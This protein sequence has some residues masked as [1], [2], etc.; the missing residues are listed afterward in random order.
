MESNGVVDDTARMPQ[1]SRFVSLASAL[2]LA[3]VTVAGCGGT[4]G[5]GGD[6]GAAD[7]ATGVLADA[8]AFCVGETNRLRATVGKAAVVQS[9]TLEDYADAGAMYDF[10]RQPHDHFRDAGGVAFAENECPHWDLSFGNG[11]LHDLVGA[12]IQAFWSEGPGGGHY[13]NMTG[14]YGSLGCGFYTEGTEYTII[15]DYR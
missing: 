8:H 1:L 14:N 3:V 11:N 7:A 6:G 12:C 2:G 4:V 13:D 9:K 10:S 15:Q 5:G